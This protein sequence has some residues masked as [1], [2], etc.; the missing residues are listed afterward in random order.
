MIFRNCVR[1]GGACS[2]T[3][4]QVTSCLTLEACDGEFASMR[5]SGPLATVREGGTWDHSAGS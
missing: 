4:N 2:R 3:E 5:S 1:Q